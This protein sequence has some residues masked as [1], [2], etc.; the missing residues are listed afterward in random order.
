MA[1]DNSWLARL[2][3]DPRM[4]LLDDSSPEVR[5]A[6]LTRLMGREA[7][8]PEV[9]EARRRAMQVDPIRAILDAQNAEGWAL[10]DAPPVYDPRT[11]RQPTRRGLK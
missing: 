6:T 8:D 5:A 10:S 2:R 7:S 3:A 4:W 11:P 1:E 9:A